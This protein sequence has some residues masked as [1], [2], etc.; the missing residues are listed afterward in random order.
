M[1]ALPEPMDVALR[2]WA[3]PDRTRNGTAQRRRDRPSVLVV[4]DCETE[5]HGAQHLLVACYRYVRVSWDKNVP[6]LTTAQEGLVV[7]DDLAERDPD[8]FALV[9]SYASGARASVEVPDHD[10]RASLVVLTRNEFCERILWKA[11]W[12]NR[13][14]LVAFNLGFDI[15]RLRLS[16]HAGRGRHRG[17]FVLRLWEWEGRDDRYRPNVI[18][19]RLDNRRCL[20]SWTGVLSPPKGDPKHRA[21]DNHFLDLR[22]L[23][24][25]LTNASHSLE[26]ACYAFGV[27]YSKRKVKLGTVSDALLDYVR[28]DVTATTRL[29]QATLAAFHRHPIALSADRAYSPAAIGGAYLRRIGIRPPRSHAQITQA[30][31][32]EAMAAFYGPRVEVRIRHLPVPVSLVDFSSQYANVARL[33]GLWDLLTAE[34]LV[35]V[36]A[37]DQVRELVESADV[38]SVLDPDFWRGLVGVALVR[39]NGDYLPTRAWFAGPGDVP[40]VGVGPLNSDRVLPLSIADVV[41]AKLATGRSPRIDS[42]WQLVGEGRAKRL[43]VAWMGGKVRFDPYADD[44]WATLIR[45]RAGLGD[46]LLANGLKA[47][48]NGTAYGNWIRLDQQPRSDSVTL[49]HR[50]GGESRQE[51]ERPEEPFLWT[52]PPFASAVTGG[53]RLLMACLERLLVDRGGLFASANTDSATI[54]SSARDGLV[55]C[56]GGPEKLPDGGDAVGALSWREVDLVRR[57]FDALD[58]P[59]NLTSENYVDGTRRQLHAIAV[60][61]SRVIL[62]RE[63]PG[64]ERQ[65]VKRSEVALGDLRSPLGPGTSATFIDETAAWML[66]FALDGTAEPRGWFGQPAMTDLPMGTPGKVESLGE[67][68]SPFG[69]ATG[70]RRARRGNSVLGGDPVRLIAPAGSDPGNAP[71]VE[72][73]TGVPVEDDEITIASYGEELV[74]LVLHPE[75]KMLGPDGLPCRYTTKGLL[76]AR[77]VLVRAVHLVGKE[78]NRIDEVATGEVTDPDEVLIEYG[79]DEWEA[80]VLPIL[81]GATVTEIA[82]RAGMD[83]AGL[84]D[85]LR[86]GSTRRPPKDTEYLL[87]G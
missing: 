66:D 7:P 73:P 5:L 30:Q 56:T 64:G 32:S 82:R 40:R 68:G 45:A 26:S 86:V 69:F 23:S 19:R 43:R 27:P 34:R 62:Y 63:L 21:E 61:G 78:G 54:V 15:S 28:E 60:A 59:L 53:G 65:V 72:V 44:W 16:W 42:A 8:A 48:G 79:S 55:A 83:R 76:T 67:N 10:P 1:T 2:A 58:V 87:S 24:F 57:R 11:C 36:D 52:F 22:T 20:F 35:V 51:V 33:L 9:H 38:E 3:V 14:T 18:A 47:I 39:P 81:R 46:S 75:S 6:T 31:L 74:R 70:A 4:L 37:T 80:V 71:W 17:A 13:A 49:Y 12:R 85:Y 77:P 41:A 50:E 84:S 25:A 29:A